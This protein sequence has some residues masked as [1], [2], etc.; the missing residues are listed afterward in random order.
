MT[1][2]ESSDKGIEFARMVA[3]LQDVLTY[4]HGYVLTVMSREGGA[5]PTGRQIRLDPRCL[6]FADERPAIVHDPDCG[7]E[8][9]TP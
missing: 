5:A 8:R 3:T 4:G 6:M 1:A 2:P 9:L 7:C